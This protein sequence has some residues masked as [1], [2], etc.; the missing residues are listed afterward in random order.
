MKTTFSGAPPRAKPSALPSSSTPNF[1]PLQ[2]ATYGF[3]S[4]FFYYFFFLISTRTAGTKHMQA[5]LC[6][7][8]FGTGGRRWDSGSSFAADT[9]KPNLARPLPPPQQKGDGSGGGGGRALPLP[10]RPPTDEEAHAQLTQRTSQSRTALKLGGGGRLAS[11]A[12][13]FAL[14]D[15][16][17]CSASPGIP[18]GTSQVSCWLVPAPRC[19]PCPQ[20][21]ADTAGSAVKP[22]NNKQLL[23]WGRC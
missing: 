20:L 5:K 9:R 18:P 7:C 14:N 15:A 13:T 11:P 21:H 1:T 10:R 2:G 22:T 6:C 23:S 16:R 19:Q 4:I 3:F 12:N 17:L 8:G